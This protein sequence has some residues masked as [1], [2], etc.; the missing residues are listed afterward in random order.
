MNNFKWCDPKDKDNQGQRV[1]AINKQTNM[2]E[3]I[4]NN[5]IDAAKALSTNYKYFAKEIGKALQ[6]YHYEVLGCYWKRVV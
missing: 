1:A 2:V 6:I 4:Y 5:V 3:N